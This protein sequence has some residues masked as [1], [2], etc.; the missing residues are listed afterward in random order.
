MVPPPQVL[1]P[2]G[3]REA[4]LRPG[5]LTCDH[6]RPACGTAT[7]APAGSRATPHPG[8]E[9][10]GTT[11]APGR[12]SRDATSIRGRIAGAKSLFDM[13][14]RI[15]PP[16]TTPPRRGPSAKADA[17]RLTGAVSA[18]AWGHRPL[19]PEPFTYRQPPAPTRHPCRHHPG[20]RT[21]AHHHQPANTRRHQPDARD[22]ACPWP[23]SPKCA[24][25]SSLVT[26][27]PEDGARMSVMRMR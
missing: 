13:A 27:A 2:A 6:R 3:T 21:T 5:Q 12:E 15:T 17:G 22:G 14:S 16:L 1:V 24:A 26:V 7:I 19:L 4:P 25:R 9:S 23:Q 11:T 18:Y 10:R 20:T 8:Q